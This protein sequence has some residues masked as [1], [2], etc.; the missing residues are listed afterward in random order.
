MS[1]AEGRVSLGGTLLRDNSGLYLG[2][3]AV[4]AASDSIWGLQCILN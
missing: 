3:V 2:S 4:A 1:S